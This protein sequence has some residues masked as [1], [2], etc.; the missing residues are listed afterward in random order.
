MM[1]KD[2]AKI[3]VGI[4]VL[5][6]LMGCVEPGSGSAIG[7]GQGFKSGTNSPG[8]SSGSG[9]GQ[10][11]DAGS[12][13]GTSG[14]GENSGTGEGS[15]TQGTGSEAG[16]PD[17][18]KI[19][20]FEDIEKINEESKKQAEAAA[21]QFIEFILSMENSPIENLTA[22]LQTAQGLGWKKEEDELMARLLARIKLEIDNRMNK[23][24]ASI[25][26]LLEAMQLSQLWGISEEETGNQVMQKI[27]AILTQKI[28]GP[29]LCKQQLIDSAEL[30]QKLGFD[31]LGELALQKFQSAPEICGKI[32]YTH[33]TTYQDEVTTITATIQGNI[34][35][36]T[37]A[38]FASEYKQYY[39]SNATM[40]WNYSQT[41][42]V[43][44]CETIEKSGSG[45][46]KFGKQDQYG[47]PDN[48][49]GVQPDGSY[50][51]SISKTVKIKITIKKNSAPVDD[52]HACDYVE[53]G[54]TEEDYDVRAEFKGTT[55]TKTYLKDGMNE[56]TPA[57]EFSDE[58][59]TTT[60]DWELKLSDIGSEI[61]IGTG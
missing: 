37:A 57:D 24:D 2:F 35:Q 18:P 17:F 25:R 59:E 36:H 44:K 60:A 9:T 43:S 33:T 49:F 38:G 15:G 28:N 4:T 7:F 27:E 34:K 41:P 20:G 39:F 13:T 51:G 32:N 58:S 48:L 12:G 45:T 6:V 54:T 40:Q 19:P 31:E 21:R 14:T 50:E 53:E 3:F 11:S 56:S 42:Q 5:I 10:G 26:E 55:Q 46:E 1:K 22:A 16:F 61:K 47:F 23:S 8:S 52:P 29:N 30:A